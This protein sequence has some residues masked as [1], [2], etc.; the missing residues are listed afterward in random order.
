MIYQYTDD[1]RLGIPVID[2]E[3]QK[4]FALINQSASMISMEPDEMRITA[5]NLITRLREYAGTHF[6]HEEAYMKQIKDPQLAS[7]PWL[8]G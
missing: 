2:E 4:L 3:H 8:Y 7:L 5:K 6:A 1:C